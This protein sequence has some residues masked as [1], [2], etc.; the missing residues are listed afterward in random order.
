MLGVP[1]NGVGG[2]TDFEIN[3]ARADPLMR[4]VRRREIGDESLTLWLMLEDD[5]DR[6]DRFNTIVA[7]HHRPISLAIERTAPSSIDRY[8]ELD[9]IPDLICLDHDLMPD[10]D[11]DPDPG[12][13]RDV[14]RFLITRFASSPVLIHS[15]NSAAADSMIFS[16][17]EH[18]WFVDRISPIGEDWIESYWFPSALDMVARFRA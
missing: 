8:K 11:S 16:M 18:G 14:S 17:R 3:V 1:C 6:I 4:S 15:T 10:C 13:G 7:R 2:R 9:V 5:L 12:D